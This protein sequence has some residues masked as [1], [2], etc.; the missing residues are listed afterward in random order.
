M[1]GFL[2]FIPVV[3][4]LFYLALIFESTGFALLSITAVAFAVLSFVSLLFTRRKV[5]A[6]LAIPAK[7]VDRDQSF[8]LVAEIK[9]KAILPIGKIKLK[10]TGG[11][12]QLNTRQKTKWTWQS[13]PKGRSSEAKRLSI[14]KSGYYEFGIKKIQIYDC[15]GFFC[16]SKRQKSIARVMVFP[17][18]EEVPVRL[19][20][21]VRNFYGETMEYDDARPGRDPSETFGYREFHDGDKLQKIHWKLS[22]RMDELMV[23]EDSHPKSCAIL[24]FM[25]DDVTDDGVSLDYAASLS[26]TLM[27]SKCPHYVVW[28]SQS[29]DDIMRVRVEDEESFYLALTSY[30]QDGARGK[31]MDRLERYRE[32]YKGDQFLHSVMAE[33]GGQIRIDGEEVMKLTKPYEELFLR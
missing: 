11:E 30:V 20:A 19:G 23:K 4:L 17:K 7:M 31:K 24:L 25:P 22:A 13:V 14:G 10:I 27:D 12:N 9:N 18:T 21:G 8:R 16:L 33:A 29:R 15:F 1:I 28:V 5:T 32:K 26:F 2:C 6:S 3:L